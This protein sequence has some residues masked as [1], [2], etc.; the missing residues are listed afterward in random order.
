M[1]PLSDAAL[2]RLRTAAALPDLS[3]TRYA[4]IREVGRGGMGTVYLAEDSELGRQV[5]LKVLHVADELMRTEA[6]TLAQ[7]EHPNIVPLYDFGH[8]ADGRLFYTMKYVEG[9]RLDRLRNQPLAARLR[10]FATVCSAVGYA[11]SK[12]LVHRDLKPANVMVGAFGEVLVMDWGLAAAA[13]SQACGRIAGTPDYMAPEQARGDS[14]I[15]PR[16]D[17]YALGKMLRFLC[18]GPA[19]LASIAAMAS[20]ERVEDR[21]ADGSAIGLEVLRYLDGLPVSAH[22]ETAFESLAR[23]YRNNRVLLLLIGAYIVTRFLVFFW[24]R[25]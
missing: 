15:D 1:K 23:W 16:A 2:E 12:G 4:L 24:T 19:P 11:H 14:A 13:G 25:R 5:A 10:L 20:A 3:G 21:Y 22:R 7:L 18:D 8:L 17:V 6:R 9:T